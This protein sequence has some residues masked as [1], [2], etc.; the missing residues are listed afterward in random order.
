MRLLAAPCVV[1]PLLG[2]A[3]LAAHRPVQRVAGGGSVD[4]VPGA[5]HHLAV[6]HLPTLPTC[7]VSPRTG[8]PLP[9][10]RGLAWASRCRPGPG[11]RLP[12][13][14][15]PTNARVPRPGPAGPRSRRPTGALT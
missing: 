1:G 10:R 9:P 6:A 8:T 13:S 4:D 7:P 15:R 14:G 11:R 5:D 12:D 3:E 2:Q